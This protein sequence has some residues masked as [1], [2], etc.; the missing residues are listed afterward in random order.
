MN[1][2]EKELLTKVKE[3]IDRFLSID[4]IKSDI[5][6]LTSVSAA[7]GKERDIAG[8]IDSLLAPCCNK[9][10]QDGIGNLIG[11][12]TAKPDQNTGS[13]IMITAHV[14]EI[15]LIVTSI[16]KRGFIRFSNIGGVDPSILLAQEVIVH[17]RCD[18][19]GI[20]GAKPPHLMSDADKKKRLKLC[21]LSIDTG[22]DDNELRSKV[23]IGDTITFKPI[24]RE[25][26]NGRICS[27]ALDNRSGL[28]AMIET[29]R[30]LKELSE[31]GIKSSSRVF[32]VA[33]AQEEFE[34]S[35]AFIAAYNIAPD[36]AII[37]DACH[38]DSHDIP[39]DESYLLG[40]GPA[41]SVGPILDKYMSKNLMEIAKE[42][43]IHYQIETEPDDTGTE[44]WAVQVSR[45]GI[46]C[47][48]ICI[49]VRYMHSAV[50][51]LQP[52]DVADLVKILTCY[53]VLH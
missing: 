31:A 18:I 37:I 39:D 25:L 11:I 36:T 15:G 14:D 1:E 48:L 47:G 29:F 35:G 44:T 13:G 6:L 24:F 22:I 32:A 12:C 3:I 33:T 49:P 42:S 10:I 26:L 4:R 41:I 38:G 30:M 2:M 21:D 7:P 45:K 53:I 5:K 8:I 19:P 43:G 20:I 28:A 16:D 52:E 40:G 34:L 27:K 46:S 51:V 9:V 23:S 50:E 17:G